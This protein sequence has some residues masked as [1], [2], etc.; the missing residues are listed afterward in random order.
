[1]EAYLPAGNVSKNCAPFSRFHLVKLLHKG[2]I[3]WR[4]I[5]VHYKRLSEKIVVFVHSVK[6]NI[7]FLKVLDRGKIFTTKK[8]LHDL[9]YKVKTISLKATIESKILGGK[10]LTK[11]ERKQ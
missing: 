6:I 7:V 8:S 2:N 11:K 5:L 3:F 1:M 9:T 10:N 4:K